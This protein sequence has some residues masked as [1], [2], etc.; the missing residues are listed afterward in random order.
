MKDV[1][2]GVCDEAKEGLHRGLNK[3]V[4]SVT[5]QQEL[6]SDWSPHNKLK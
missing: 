4:K 1:R 2:D 6:K 5:E 3:T